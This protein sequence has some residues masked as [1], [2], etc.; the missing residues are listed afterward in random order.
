MSGGYCAF[1]SQQTWHVPS[2]SFIAT[3]RGFGY[4]LTEERLPEGLV[5]F[6]PLPDDSVPYLSDTD[7]SPHDDYKD[8]ALP[9]PLAARVLSLLDDE[10]ARLEAALST[11]ELRAVGASVLVVYEGDP[12]R[13]EQALERF[14]AKRVTLAARS[15]AE[16]LDD[17]DDEEESDEEIESDSEDS[18]TDDGVK[19][20]ERRA[21]KC[22]PL[23]VRLIDFAHT[24]LVEGE[25]PDQGVLLGLKTF[26]GLVQRRRDE[27]EAWIAQH[28]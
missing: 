1:F 27:V 18:D 4:N 8:H 5:R 21:A 28:S 23:V 24:W 13:L 6:F 17:D 26:R 7:T 22:P 12:V 16:G 14:A 10:L 11:I 2:Q 15:L 19:A 25:G 3:P 9:P 20:D